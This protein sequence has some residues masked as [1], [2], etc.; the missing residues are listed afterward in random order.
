MAKL[1]A[2]SL[3]YLGKTLSILVDPG[4]SQVVIPIRHCWY[5]A[6]VASS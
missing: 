3:T 6:V 4:S 1:V 5:F 2:R